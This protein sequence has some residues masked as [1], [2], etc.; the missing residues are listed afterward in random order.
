MSLPQTEERIALPR[1]RGWTRQAWAREQKPVLRPKT[2]SRADLPLLASCAAL[3]LVGWLALSS[4]G[5]SEAWRQLAYGCGGTILALVAAVM[6][7]R[8]LQHLVWPL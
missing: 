6:S 2:F 4:A 7:P 3:C 5:P 8:R 1:H